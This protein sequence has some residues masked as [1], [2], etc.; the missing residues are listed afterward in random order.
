MEIMNMRGEDVTSKTNGTEATQQAC[1]A[2][3]ASKGEVEALRVQD[4]TARD[5]LNH[6]LTALMDTKIADFDQ[7]L[8][9]SPVEEQLRQLFETTGK[10]EK[11]CESYR[12][13]FGD[14]AK[15]DLAKEQREQEAQ[16][17]QLER[18]AAKAKDGA[19]TRVTKAIAQV[20]HDVAV[21]GDKLA[22]AAAQATGMY[23]Q[24]S[25]LKESLDS[26]LDIQSIEAMLEEMRKE[27]SMQI[28][29]EMLKAHAEVEREKGERLTEASEA[30]HETLFYL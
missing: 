12:E 7:E 1:N 23:A 6:D 15:K 19:K 3:V 8:K 22:N 18:Q 16:L 28:Q 29:S 2:T 17:R 21:K 30:A 4:S 25:K 27:C 14:Q 20:K 10:L 13:Q 5:L 11:E 24:I 9:A 26:K